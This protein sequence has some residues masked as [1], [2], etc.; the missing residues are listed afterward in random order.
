MHP[1]YFYLFFRKRTFLSQSFAGTEI[2][3]G[4]YKKRI[5]DQ[6][7]TVTLIVK[8]PEIYDVQKIALVVS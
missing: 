2:A 3:A 6:G 1:I 7:P 5:D 8:N 4:L